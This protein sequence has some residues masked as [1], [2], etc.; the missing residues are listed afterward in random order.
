MDHNKNIITGISSVFSQIT[1]Q[2]F[3]ENIKMEKQRTNLPYSFIIKKMLN[4]PIGYFNGF[5]PYGLFQSFGKGYIISGT[6]LFIEP[7]I[8]KNINSNIK[9]III[10]ISTGITESIFL[11]PLTLMRVQLNKNIVDKEKNKI[12]INNKNVIFKGFLGLFLKRSLDWTS[13]YLFIDKFKKISP[14]DNIIFN[15]FFASG[16]STIIS[17]PADR[18]LPLIFSN[19]NILK[20]YNKQKIKFFYNGFIFRFL[21]TGY[22]TTCL[23]L[24][25]NEITKFINKQ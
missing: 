10:G 13:R 21:S 17:T 14:I 23:F 7:K 11:T 5:M 15:T 24:I 1:G 25:P 18:I 9:N 6:K 16:L 3:L 8:N 12:S 4:K 19:E 20:I 2:L 22:Y